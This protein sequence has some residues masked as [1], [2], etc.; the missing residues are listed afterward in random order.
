MRLRELRQRGFAG[1]VEAVTA[2]VEAVHRTSTLRE[3]FRDCRLN[4]GFGLSPTG[5]PVLPCNSSLSFLSLSSCCYLND[6]SST[7]LTS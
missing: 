6:A 3:R 7:V 4:E 5:V 2:Y 1:V